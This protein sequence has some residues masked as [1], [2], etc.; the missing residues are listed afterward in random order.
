MTPEEEI[1][2]LKEKVDNLSAAFISI[3]SYTLKELEQDSQIDALK[4]TVRYV[5]QEQ[6]MKDEVFFKIFKAALDIYMDHHL[7]KIEDGDP[8]LAALVDQRLLKDVPTSRE[9][10][11]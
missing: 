4:S 11:D 9:F 1:Q 3:S 10:P 5:C 2:S 7:R 6:G 8:A